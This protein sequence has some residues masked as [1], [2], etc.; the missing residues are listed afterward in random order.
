MSVVAANVSPMAYAQ[1]KQV[2]DQ[3]TIV[4]YGTPIPKGRPR[5]TR[6]GRTYTPAKTK[7][8]EINMQAAWL[9]TAG[10]KRKPH[11]GPVSIEYRAYFVPPASWPKWKRE[12]ALDGHLLHTTK[13]DWDNLAKTIDG[14]NGVAWLD[15][16]QVFHAIATKHYAVIARTEISITFYPELDARKEPKGTK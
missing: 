8:A 12:A 10:N 14:L 15:D 7:A 6:T 13:P 5:F 1:S 11:A 9:L 2:T 4:M 3:V 16:S